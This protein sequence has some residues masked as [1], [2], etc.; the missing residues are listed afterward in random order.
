MMSQQPITVQLRY[1][2]TLL[3]IGASNNSTIIFPI[4]I[5]LLTALSNAADRGAG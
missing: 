3:E 5:D 2:Q 4:P 1:L